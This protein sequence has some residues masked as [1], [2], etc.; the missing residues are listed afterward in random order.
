M[1]VLAAVFIVLGAAGVVAALLTGTWPLLT[2]GVFLVVGVVLAATTPATRREQTM[3]T[4]AAP[5][6]PPGTVSFD[7]LAERIRT[8]L[9]G[10]PWTVELEGSRILVHAD[11]ADATFLTW[12]SVHHVEVVRALEIVAVGPGRAV[13]RDIE[14]D[15]DLSAGVGRLSGTVRVQS[16]RSWSYQRRI[17]YGVGTDGSVGRQVDV[18]FSSARLRGPVT[19]VLKETGWHQGAWVS[20]PAEAKGAAVVA[21]IG[22]VGGIVGGVV[23][24]VLALR[25]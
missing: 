7:Q 23:A 18:E 8:R 4:T 22:G 2:A 10:E 16:G 11:L 13:T 5:D 24:A 21:V 6:A 17:E 14:R 3:G 1:A 9:A 19:D 20:L 25:G 15:L 12:A